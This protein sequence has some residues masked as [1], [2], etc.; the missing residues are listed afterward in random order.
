MFFF[1]ACLS[2]LVLPAACQL[3][4]SDEDGFHPDSLTMGTFAVLCIFAVLYSVLFLWSFIPIISGRGHRLPYLVLLPTVV[5]AAWSNATYGATIVLNN[6]PALEA[7]DIFE[8]ELPVLL[9]PALGFVSDLFYHWTFVF[10]F[11]VVILLLR[12]REAALRATSAGRDAL[13][14][15]GAASMV[16]NAVHVALAVLAF[17]FGTAHAG[18]EM[19]TSVKYDNVNNYDSIFGVDGLAP[20]YLHRIHVEQ[21]LY[22]THNSFI[23][24][25][26][27]DVVATTV[28]LWRA[29]RKAG[30]TDTITT[31][32]L[33]VLAPLY[34]VFCILLM[35]FTI[36][37]S[38]SGLAGTAT[39]SNNTIESSNL[40]DNILVTGS[41]IAILFV[42]LT[43]SVR[44]AWWDTDA[45][46]GAGMA[47]SAKQEYWG[48]QP[49]YTYAAA[50]P[51]QPG[52]YIPQQ[53]GT[54][55]TQPGTPYAHPAQMPGPEMQAQQGHYTPQHEYAAP[56]QA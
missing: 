27:I 42:I 37:F 43:L 7:N 49:A 10:Q 48:Q 34:S 9:L 14:P 50:P 5:F 8:T 16:M 36:I 12:N 19:A 11:A 2:S 46:G 18:L 35:A 25:T 45:Y 47:A 56:P 40:A 52:Y 51:S 22:W 15:V 3:E 23:I 13:G 55:Y 21:Q 1:L 28:V 44:R 4:F 32:L 53:P 24:L 17:T 29:W 31:R 20:D 38:P 26:S 6:I 54:P 41:S 33:T 30:L 39:A